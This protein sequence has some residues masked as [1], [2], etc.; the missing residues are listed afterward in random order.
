MA[1]P[2]FDVKQAH[3][4]FAVELNNLSW[5]LVE[6]DHITPA[7]AERMIHAAHAACFHWLEAGDLLNH[8]RA[9]CLLATAYT[10]AGLRE[11]A[12][13]HAERCLNLSTQASDRQTAFDRAMAHGCAAAAFKLAGRLEDAEAEYDKAVE[14][15]TTFDD[16]S[17]A[18]VFLKLYSKN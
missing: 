1:I 3:R 5:D 9:Q 17:E 4:W 15:T 11:S 2:P 13:R 10:K 18:S 7:D 14:A 12:V 6:A 8:L 16:P